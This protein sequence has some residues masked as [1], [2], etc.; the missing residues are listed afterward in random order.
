ML[1]GLLDRD[2]EGLRQTADPACKDLG[3]HLDNPE[4]RPRDGLSRAT[5][6]A[7][8]SK[9]HL[10]PGRLALRKVPRCFGVSC[11]GG[12]LRD[13]RSRV[14]R[15]SSDWSPG[16]DTASERVPGV[17]RSGMPRLSRS[18]L[19]VSSLLPSNLHARDLVLPGSLGVL[20]AHQ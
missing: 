20:R 15:L 1:W 11:K 13:L 4:N 19:A 8:L 3:R 5:L 7:S 9:L 16:R 18:F 14:C 2:R 17:R 12:G 6:A 10:R